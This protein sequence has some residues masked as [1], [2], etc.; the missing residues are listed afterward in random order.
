MGIF[1]GIFGERTGV[2]YLTPQEVPGVLMLR[3]V[4]DTAVP[5]L[6]IARDGMLYRA[7]LTSPGALAVEH[8]PPPKNPADIVDNL[9][10]FHPPLEVVAE[11]QPPQ[12]NIVNMSDY[13]SAASEIRLVMAPQAEEEEM[14]TGARARIDRIFRTQPA[15][16]ATSATEGTFYDQ[17]AA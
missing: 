10:G 7:G 6:E 4:A 11:V 15:P 9:I 16:N 13:R 2:E 8:T 5:R 17:K 12:S 1:E 3:S 14:A